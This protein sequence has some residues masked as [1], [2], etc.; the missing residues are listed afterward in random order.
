M[1]AWKGER[2]RE[3]EMGAQTVMP[4]VNG[5]GKSNLFFLAL[6][7]TK[8][9]IYEY[10]VKYS[11]SITK[12]IDEESKRVEEANKQN[13]ENRVINETE[14]NEKREHNGSESQNANTVKKNTIK[15]S[16]EFL[17]HRGITVYREFPDVEI[18][19]CTNSHKKIIIVKKTNLHVAEIIDISTE[20]K[21]MSITTKTPIKRIM[22]SPNNTFVVLH[23][24][25]KPEIS[26]TNLFVYHLKKG[27]ED[28]QKENVND[29][30][31]D[32]DKKYNTP[33]IEVTVKTFNNRNWPFF[34]WTS[35]ELYC[36][37]AMNNHIYVY[38]NNDLLNPVK[39]MRVNNLNFFELSPET[40]KKTFL[41][42]T[43]EDGVKSEQSV[44]KIFQME[45]LQTHLYVKQ[46]FTADE[47]KIKWNQRATPL[48][49]QVHSQIDKIKQSYYGTSSLYFVN[50]FTS[51]DIRIMANEGLIYDTIW[52]NNENKFYICKGEMPAEISVYDRNGEFLYTYGS[53]KY[54]TLKLNFNEKMLLTGGFGNLSGDICIWNTQT[55]KEITKTKASCAVI[56]EFFNDGKH[57]LTATTH[58][59]LRV[60]NDIK[61]YKYNGLVVSR[62]TF[63]ELY[64]VTILP[65]H[66]IE[67]HSRDASVDLNQDCSK[68]D[69]YINK[70]L[71]IDK[72][73]TGI[74]RAPVLARLLEKDPNYLKKCEKK[75]PTHKPGALFVEPNNANKSKNKKKKKKK[76]KNKAGKEED[77]GGK[78]KEENKDK[79]EGTQ[80]NKEEKKE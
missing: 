57:F 37:C 22:V 74:Y 1:C 15:F 73:K 21:L 12:E 28:L 25:Y 43:Y 18:A 14:R 53:H 79:N 76:S 72:K 7:K 42:A 35:N 41:L 23:C 69:D 32:V 61:I 65:L 50:A 54:N 51:R 45:D 2:D 49:L 5:N 38:K 70:Q 47:V 27:V 55:K 29:G 6:S 60:D 44:F 63:D 30:I 66:K 71:G 4:T 80:G 75:H 10:D 11:K 13:N 58:P 67:F 77:T 39:Q 33:I 3:R 31:D 9:T 8:A 52:S 36:C 20:K 56:C 17:L 68:F 19:V 59:R 40:E 24:Q 16:N 48:L 46:F 26:P 78:D 64:N 34:K 62:I